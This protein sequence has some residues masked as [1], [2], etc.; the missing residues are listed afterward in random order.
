M[1]FQRSSIVVAATLEALEDT[2]SE[3]GEKPVLGKI[4][5]IRRA[6]SAVS[7]S[8]S[9]KRKTDQHPLFIFLIPFLP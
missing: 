7:R 8:T 9:R 1:M 5:L 3:A 2:D 4:S 6:K